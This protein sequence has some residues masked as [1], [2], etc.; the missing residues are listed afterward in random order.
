MQ[1][2]PITAP[3]FRESTTLMAPLKTSWA[4][5][6]TIPQA[7]TVP[8]TIKPLTIPSSTK[9]P[10]P[11]SGTP[12]L[13]TNMFI[14]GQSSLPRIPFPPLNAVPSQPDAQN[15][16]EY[17]SD[18][19]R[20][21]EQRIFYY[22]NIERAKAGKSSFVYDSKLSDIARDD[23]VD[24]ATRNFFDHINPD[25][26]GP[27]ER[28]KRHGYDVEKDYHTYYRIGV[29]ENIAMVQHI[30]G[31][32]DE[33]AQFIVN[34]WMNSPDHRENI[35]DLNGAD[36]TNLGV[37]VAYDSVNDKYLAVQEFF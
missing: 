33:V 11:T 2:T 22:T 17:V 31:T 8:T 19:T 3:G 5:A 25:G 26:E 28:A 20:T 16:R 27:T 37:G 9:F 15:T 10:I 34:A 1:A 32:P 6:G 7:D 29:G 23:A 24:M 4:P 30:Q 14:T 36:Y 12:L 35:L 18:T 21:V 13:K